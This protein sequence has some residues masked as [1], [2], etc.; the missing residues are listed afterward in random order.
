MADAAIK[1]GRFYV[2]V[3]ACI[4]FGRARTD[5]AL[6]NRF[7]C[8]RR[9]VNDL[10][11]RMAALGLI[12]V[13]GWELSGTHWMPVWK[14][15][16]KPHAPHPMGKVLQKLRPRQ[17]V[18]AFAALWSE[19]ETASTTRQLMD[20]SGIDRITLGRIIKHARDLRMV[21]IAGWM[22]HPGQGARIP[23]YALGGAADEPRPAARPMA[24]LQ[25][26]SAA[27]IAA[28]E[29]TSLLYAAITGRPL[30][31]ARQSQARIAGQGA[32]A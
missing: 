32:A 19:L 23:M 16:D 25:R 2:S 26:E 8:N 21:R 3:L 28:R 11:K 9:T 13:S 22:P 30:V 15:G 20:A 31:P 12:H 7:K 6:R 10:T 24:E 18:T 29:K 4:R 5:L 17:D 27:R 14:I 1:G